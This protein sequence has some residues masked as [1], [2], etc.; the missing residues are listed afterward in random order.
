MAQ[1][2][3]KYTEIGTYERF[4]L[5]PRWYVPIFFFKMAAANNC[6]PMPKF[7]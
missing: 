4:P 5:Q 6:C 2:V 1:K 3:Q 7:I